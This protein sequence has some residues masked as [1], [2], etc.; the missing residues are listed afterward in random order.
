MAGL[1]LLAAA[2]D[3]QATSP[4]AEDFQVIS[5]AMTFMK[6]AKRTSARI[7]IVYDAADPH[8]TAEASVAHAILTAGMT[9]GGVRLSSVRLD[10]DH[11]DSAGSYDAIF[12]V[13]GVDQELL[14]AFLDAGGTPCFTLDT[15]QVSDG[16]CT[17]A[18]RTAPSVNISLNSRN[19]SAAG[20][21]FATAFIMMVQEL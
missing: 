10:Q 8:S 17:V 3:T 21:A 6:G 20:V 9:V 18:V 5:R 19:A 1:V 2:S 16:A 13:G 4:T 14:S 7:A 15:R 11:L 12:S